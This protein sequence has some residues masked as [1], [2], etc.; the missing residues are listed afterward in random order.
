[1]LIAVAMGP[2]ACG[3]GA[4]Q[5]TLA[6][7]VARG[8]HE[9]AADLLAAGADP[10]EPRV[11]GLTP[12]MRAANRDDETM[13][14]ILIDAGADLEETAPEGLTAIHIAAQADAI[15]AI[16]SLIRAGADVTVRSSNGMNALDHAAAAGAVAVVALLADHG[17]DID[18]QSQVITQGH[19]YPR[20][21][22]APPLGIAARAGQVEVVAALLER[23]AEVDAMSA[24]GHTP[25]LLA[26]FSNQSVDVVSALVDAGADPRI[27]ASCEQ[28]CSFASGD[29]LDWARQL[30]RADLIAPLEAAEGT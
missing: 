1:M 28:G 25:L 6:D 3:G 10:E 7:A 23:G 2:A 17:V 4:S 29:A 21:V 30:G 12:L 22:G 24:S 11:H 18:A 8:D 20:D 9:L 15:A 19:G 5:A 16:G 27:E 26:V 13:V 14:D